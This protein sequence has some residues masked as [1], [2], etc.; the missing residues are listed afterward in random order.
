MTDSRSAAKAAKR[1]RAMSRQ[2]FVLERT[3]D[4]DQ[5]ALDDAVSAKLAEPRPRPKGRGLQPKGF[6]TSD[7][8]RWVPIGPSV[9]RQGQGSGRPRVTGRIRDLAVHHEGK[10]AYAASA[11]GGV[12]YT[13]DGGSTWA[14]VGGWAER[15]VGAGGP[16]NAQ[17][18]GSLLVTF[19][20]DVNADF[21][22]VGTGETVPSVSTFTGSWGGLGVLAARGPA[23]R[24][25]GDNPWE[26]ES[27]L[28]VLGGLGVFKLVRNPAS[29]AESTAGA[30]TDK[31]LAATSAG[32]YLGTRT[33]GPPDSFSWAKLPGINALMAVAPTFTHPAPPVFPPVVPAGVTPLV[34]PAVTDVVWVPGGGPNGRIL[35]TITERGLAYSDDGGTTFNWVTGLNWPISGQTVQG[36]SSMALAPGTNTLYVLTGLRRTAGL[37]ANIDDDTALF[38]IPDITPAGGAAPT[39]AIR[40]RGVQSKLWPGQRDYDQAIDVDVVAVGANPA[41]HRVYLAG[42]YFEAVPSTFDASLWCYDVQANDTLAP[43]PGISRRG[44]P[45]AG[46]GAGDGAPV[47]SFIGQGVHADVHVVRLV[48][49]TPATRQLW[50]GCDGG[51]YVSTQAG[52][53]H[54]FAPRSTGLGTLEAG[55]SA[56]HPTSSHFVAA[57]LQDNGSQ[58]RAGDT[59]WEEI[60]EGDG[61]GIVFDPVQPHRIV[62]QYITSSWSASPGTAFVSPTARF[63][64]GGS[65]DDDREFSQRVSSFYSG[66]AVTT[67]AAGTTRLAVGTNRIWITDNLGTANPNTWR[68]LRF[69][70]G[71]PLDARPNGNDPANRRRFGVPAGA[72]GLPNMA[73]NANFGPLGQVTTLRWVS[74]TQLLVLFS[75]GV[76]SW[77]ETA[78]GNWQ[79]AVILNGA[80]ILATA[81]GAV[82]TVLTDIFPI[83]GTNDFYL[84]T[85]GSAINAGMDTCLLY[86]QPGAAPGVLN[87]T[88]LRTVLNQAGP[89][90]VVGPLDPAYA[91]VVDPSDPLQVYVG[92]VTGVW[93]GVRTAGT[94]TVAWGPTPFVNGLPQAAVQDL[95]IHYDPTV[96]ARP[97]VPATATTPA[98]PATPA[99][100]LLRASIQARGVWEVDLAVV[101]QPIRTYLRVHPQDDRRRLPTP[102]A[103]VR[104][105]PPGVAFTAFESPD[106]TVRPESAAQIVPQWQ[107][108]AGTMSMTAANPPTY[109]LWTFQ[110]AFRWLFPSVLATGIWSPSFQQLVLRRRIELGMSAQPII[111]KALWD[112]IVATRVDPATGAPS[113]NVAH[114][115]AVYRAPWQGPTA[116]GVGAT[117]V[118]LVEC[119]QPV[120][121]VGGVWQ[122]HRERNTVEVLLHH[123]DTRPLTPAQSHVVLLW[124][125]APAM[126][127]LQGLGV[128][129]VMPFL[130]Q[131]ATTGNVQ[132]GLADW[133][134]AGP[135]A[136]AAVSSLGVALDAR[137]P[138]AASFDV[139]LSSVDPA[140]FVLFLAVAWSDLDRLT[141]LPAGFPALPALPT[142]ADLVR[143]WP[144]AAA[145]I[146]QVNPRPVPGP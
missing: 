44:D 34:T 96:P 47:A 94:S 22:L 61:G 93:H 98:I 16:N 9:V 12:W 113:N 106:I 15:P 85:T 117:E 132:A 114:P 57:G 136:G 17:S 138:R 27:G 20:A 84:T 116:M 58:V 73:A 144:Y 128:A 80:T 39:A 7:T 141:V 92:T 33:A 74:P 52:R 127:T 107:L 82:R 77:T 25:I 88:N 63:A 137:I 24:P 26:V 110:T 51:V 3:G 1:D 78:P 54:T 41:V 125:S 100:R 71:A 139:D 81:P 28:A 70:N 104:R 112:A 129:D 31:V 8:S 120:S 87:K 134:V 89:P 64:G 46:A 135:A 91:V 4:F 48:G 105:P 19:G 146:V 126:P 40:V 86:T 143:G 99:P 75:A 65:N 68:V 45:G 10:R 60:F 97:A 121:S 72:L 59:V 76:M 140:N 142:V 30:T 53:T 14:P 123:R 102:M 130:A 79:A 56:G 21:V 23:G 2:R 124:R 90:V 118:D 6:P 36:H 49:D 35:V 42:S 5:R 11:R 119:V 111:D 133:H 38:R 108:G 115:L 67:T 122:V 101:D 66:A 145:R 95:T 13:G 103:D 50:V 131:C 62:G 29:T 32:L 83:T 109:Q 18:C 43:A 37:P 55:F 69:P